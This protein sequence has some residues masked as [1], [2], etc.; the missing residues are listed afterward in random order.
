MLSRA[1]FRRF[2][3]LAFVLTAILFD[4]PGKNAW[5]DDASDKETVISARSMHADQNTGIVTATG[6]VEI[7]R[8]GYILHADQVT[9][10]QKKGVMHAEGH[11]AML[12]PAG[13]VQFAD[14]EDVTG[15]MKQAFIQNIAILFPDNSRMVGHNGQRYDGRYTVAD[16]ATY[17]AC[18]ICKEDPTHPPIWQLRAKEIV[19]DNEEHNI[20]YHDATLD[21]GSVPVFYTPYMSSPDPTVDRRQGFLSPAPGYSPTIGAY[22]QTPYY[23]DISPDKDATVATTFSQKD[24]LQLGGTYRERFAQGFLQLNGSFTHADLLN[25]NA[26]DQGYQWRGHL[27]GKFVYDI[28]NVWR[29]GSDVNFASDKT[30]LMRYRLG[31]ANELTTRNYAEGFY[32]RDYVSVNNY[33]FE[34][35]RPGVTGVQP[36]VL[37]LA[38]FSALG[39][40][41]RMFGGRWSL[42]GNTLLTARDNADKGLNQQGPDTRRMALNGGWERQIISERTGLVTKLSTLLHLDAY[43]ADNVVDPSNNGTIY[44]RVFFARQFEQAN[45]VVSYPLSRSGDGYQQVLEPIAALTLAPDF[46]NSAKQPIEDS[47]DINFD[48]TNLFSPNRFTG[49]DLIEGGSRATYGLRH[50]LTTDSNGR[51]ELFGGQSYDFS[52]N[53][54]FTGTSGLHDKVSDYVG[55]IAFTPNQY[56]DMAYSFRLNH[57]SLER[58]REYATVSFGAPIFRPT[59]RYTSGFSLGTTGVIEKIDDTT[60][61]FDSHFA[62]YWTFHVDHTQGFDPQPGPRSTSASLSYGDECLVGA[63]SIAQ[64]DAV[65]AGLSSGTSVLFHL[66]LRNLGG[67]HTDGATSAAFPTEFRQMY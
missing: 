29:A 28:D 67:I 26:I 23:F 45:G 50:M 49:Y 59:I 3:I 58:E 39:E 5:A 52:R 9:Y 57:K 17:T 63:V 56:V 35:L 19:H 34:D 11:V 44:N 53:S 31:S 8:A 14:A 1:R 25:D 32:G 7:A 60:V 33:Y 37:P 48:E 6:R 22:L 55:R 20:Y 64:N 54:S 47:Q 13:D 12:T 15:D 18:D 51:V 16:N 42:D 27:F 10:D 38:N 43:S 46:Y 21:I 24:K 4:L 61:G 2:T 66:F 36:I 30:Y 62:K 41:G 65:Q 40:P